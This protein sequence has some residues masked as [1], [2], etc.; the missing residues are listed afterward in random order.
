MS[1]TRK[2]R[3]VTRKFMSFT[4]KFSEVTRKFRRVT[5]KITCFTREFQKWPAFFVQN[6]TY[7]YLRKLFSNISVKIV[8]YELVLAFNNCF[9]LLTQFEFSCN[10]LNNFNLLAH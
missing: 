5:R 9:F 10:I 2:C 4:R 8:V 6:S 3:A 1:F 7:F